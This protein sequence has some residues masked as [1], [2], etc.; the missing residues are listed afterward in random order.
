M[1]WDLYLT[2]PRKSPRLGNLP[3]PPWA[4]SYHQERII[5][6]SCIAV[7]YSRNPLGIQGPARHSLTGKPV[8]LEDWFEAVHIYLTLY[9]KTDDKIM[10]MVDMVINS[11]PL[12]LKRG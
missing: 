11:F 2:L 6:A 1:A 7:A 5:I 4:Y 9:G 3:I 12:T 8:E 10:Y